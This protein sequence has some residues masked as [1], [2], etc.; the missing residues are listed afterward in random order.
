MICVQGPRPETPSHMCTTC[1]CL[2]HLFSCHITAH[3]KMYW[4]ENLPPP[5]LVEHMLR[6]YKIFN[7]R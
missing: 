5:P 2:C 7:K 6:K 4:E 3:T 1:L